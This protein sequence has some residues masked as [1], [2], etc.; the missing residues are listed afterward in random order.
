MGTWDI[1]YLSNMYLAG[2]D[3]SSSDSAQCKVNPVTGLQVG[4]P[5]WTMNVVTGSDKIDKLQCTA[6]C[7]SFSKTA[8][9]TTTGATC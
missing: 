2:M 1:C 7:F 5:S 9:G 4:R 6:T 3:D 8:T